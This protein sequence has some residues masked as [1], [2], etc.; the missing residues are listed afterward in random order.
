[1]GVGDFFRAL[2]GGQPPG[3]TGKAADYVEYQKES[4]RGKLAASGRR[5]SMI[6]LLNELRVYLNDHLKP[7]VE[8]EGYQ[9]D[10]HPSLDRATGSR[11]VIMD[12][13]PLSDAKLHTKYDKLV[14][15]KKSMGK[16]HDVLCLVAPRANFKKYP[17]G[18]YPGLL[19]FCIKPDDYEYRLSLIHI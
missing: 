10:D 3:E 18:T 7:V 13:L 14:R 12:A 2:F 5:V 1:M 17:R 4:A 15:I 6:T 16:T 19:Y 9:Y 8:A 11:I